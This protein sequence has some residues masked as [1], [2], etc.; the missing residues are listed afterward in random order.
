MLISTH[1][2]KF[3]FG[4][5]CKQLKEQAIAPYKYQHP[6]TGDWYLLDIRKISDEGIYQ[7]LKLISPDYPRLNNLLPASTKVLSSKQLSEHIKWVERWAA[8]NGVEMGYISDEWERVLNEAG[9]EKE[10]K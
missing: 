6:L 8:Q 4:V 3:F 1:F 10:I 9:I 2:Q 7:L 5:V